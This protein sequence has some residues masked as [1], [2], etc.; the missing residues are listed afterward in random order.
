MPKQSAYH[1]AIVGG[2]TG[3]HIMPALAV[4]EV[5]RQQRQTISFIGSTGGP[6]QELVKQAN[7]PFYGIQAGKL[8]RYLDWRNIVDV[9]KVVVGI[10]QAWRLLRRLSPDVVFAKG[11][12]VSVP[13]V[14]V[15]S[16]LNI[17][18]VAHESDAVMGLANRLAAQKATVI[19]TG[20]PISSYPASLRKKLR[21]TGNPIRQLFR[22]KLPDRA[23]LL[24]K[25]HLE[26]KR[27]ILLVMG[28]SQGA[29][30]LNQLV[31]DGLDALLERWQVIHLTGP[32]DSEWAQQVKQQLPVNRDA[33]YLPYGFVGEEM[34]ELLSLAD[35]VVS[36]S[37]ANSI[38]E[39]AALGKATVLVPLPSAASDHQRMNARL[40]AKKE[41]AVVVEQSELTA[42]SLINLLD[43]LMT[44]SE[45][46]AQLRRS[47]KAF[48]SPQAAE[49]IAEAVTE[50]ATK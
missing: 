42:E 1:V 44:D 31:I 21:F 23:S 26:A 48:Y 8:R 11:G 29:H 32:A 24:K 19:C 22:Q 4:A 38:A 10:W 47:I 12:Y 14:Y 28:S 9:V 36:R 3:G 37:S 40:L 49:L 7:L 18:V 25:Y 27:P 17:P 50:V 15:A 34:A 43:E 6:E 16:W 46:L 39:L 35:V 41:A 45:R 5:L 20:F 13:V 33:A 2:G 30:A